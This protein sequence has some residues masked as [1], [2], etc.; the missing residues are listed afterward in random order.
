MKSIQTKI[1]IVILAILMV[2]TVLFIVTTIFRTNIILDTDSEQIIQSTADYYC[3]IIDDNFRS[4]EQSVGSIY[5]YAMKR[6]ETYTDFLSDEVQRDKYTNDISELAQSIAENTRGA[7][8]VY[9]R[10]NPEDYG[11]RNG[12]WYTINL[13]NGSW[14]SSVPTDMSL[15]EKDDI[16]HVGWYYVPIE[17]GVPMWMEPYFNRNLGVEMISYV[18][19]YYYDNYTVGIIGMDIDM[20]V[21]R[22]AV[23]KISVYENGKAFMMSQE[24]DIIYHEYYREGALYSELDEADK[25]YFSQVLRM[26]PDAVN[27]WTSKEGEQQKVILKKLRNGMIFGIYAPLEEIQ[28]PQQR[29]LLQLMIIAATIF[30]LAIIISALL[31]RT[32]IKPLKK[33][34]RVAEHYANGDFEDEMSV[35]S[36]DEVGILSGS[37]QVMATS[38]K[39]QIEIANSANKAKS[40]FLANMSHEIR[41]PINAVLGMNEMIL[42]EADDE[43]IL[44]YSNNIQTA[45]RTLLSIINSILDFSK[46]EDGKMD[47]IP[48]NYDTATVINNLVNSISERAK[49]KGLNLIIDIDEHLPTVLFGDDVRVTQVI[50][51]L[52]TNAVKYTEKGDV[53]LSIRDGGREDGAVYLD[54]EVKDTGIGIRK[55]D[56]EK[57]YESFTR[58]E[59]KRNRN[60]EGTGLGMAIVAKLLTMMDSELKVNSVYG[61]GSVFSFRL[62]QHIVDEQ[63]IGNYE[64]RIRTSIKQNKARETF[65]VEGAEILVVDDNEMN[66]KVAANLMKIYG[67]VP[68][69]AVSGNE[70]IEKM[71][72]KSYNIVFLDHMMP[73]MD[74]VE[75]LK[76]IREQ[77]IMDSTTAMI[78]LTANA[79]VGAKEAYLAD[80]FDDYLSKPIEL[81][82]LEKILLEY[83]PEHMI[84]M[85]NNEEKGNDNLT[86]DYAEDNSSDKLV[87]LEFAPQD[88]EGDDNNGMDGDS[89]KEQLVKIGISYEEGIKYCGNS[90]DFYREILQDY[91]NA[92]SEK[93]AELSDYYLHQDWNSYRIVIHSTKSTSKAIGANM[94]Y[95]PALELEKAAKNEDDIYIMDNH[96]KFIE[97][98]R[99]ISDEIRKTLQ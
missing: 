83:L 26:K 23:A 60:I 98:Y 46:I 37:L 63:P 81:D 14:Q 96:D 92:Y 38:L 52:L 86:I 42:R 88:S 50:M 65:K 95:E 3:N 87:L 57:L 80:G 16:E 20:D 18:I 12:F 10:Y 41:T 30:V 44:E 76:E 43:T 35:E 91:V 73:G 59:E 51:N 68:D 94:I 75:T 36:D 39:E 84:K 54:V 21:L 33:M 8:A 62:K 99:E 47:I 82:K 29:L 27:M 55:E 25:E 17:A 49:N 1:S 93:S 32:I 53:K 34:T 66:L 70:T 58:I 79:I 97:L 90:I 9:L 2:V 40:Q 13:E 78:A 71:R 28:A 24:G 11:S 69:M 45:G 19:P 64:E 7:M 77:N 48:V 6:A 72:K 74:G 85:N 67:I 56:M 5:N 15:Y 22:E 61:E 31:V 4:A 89:L